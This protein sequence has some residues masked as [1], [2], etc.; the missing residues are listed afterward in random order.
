MKM[1]MLTGLCLSLFTGS[2][3]ARIGETVKECN[4]RYGKPAY[5]MKKD[6]YLVYKKS[7]FLIYVHF[8]K[9]RAS[10]IVYQGKITDE[11]IKTLQKANSDLVWRMTEPNL[12]LTSND[13][14]I[15]HHTPK[16]FRLTVMT[17]EFFKHLKK[18]ES[19]HDKKR[20]EGL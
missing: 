12:W 17:M 5:E 14:I 1:I 7:K 4:G 10:R 6:K 3:F 16:N 8:H 11:T 15:S 20:L 19:A 18:E 2:A 9:G 13:S